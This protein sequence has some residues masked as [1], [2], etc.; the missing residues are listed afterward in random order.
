MFVGLWEGLVRELLD[1]VWLD[2]KFEGLI[3]DARWLF[4]VGFPEQAFKF[5][6]HDALKFS[7][8]I[9]SFKSMTSELTQ[10][11][12]LFPLSTLDNT[13]HHQLMQLF[14]PILL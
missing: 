13:L 9:F 11:R 6:P 8:N 3:T 2:E 1:L 10:I 12:Y 4:I 5:I 14:R 7:L